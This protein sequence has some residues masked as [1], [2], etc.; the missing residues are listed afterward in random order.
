MFIPKAPLLLVKTQDHVEAV[1][2]E[3]VRF[4][5][6]RGC[7]V[8]C[9]SAFASTE[10]LLDVAKDRDLLIVLGGDGTL[11]SVARKL[12][13][14]ALPFLAFNFG[15]IGFLAEW[16]P[17]TWQETLTSLIAGELVLQSHAGLKWSCQQGGT[18]LQQGFAVNDVVLSRG[19]LARVVPLEIRLND[20]LVA[21]IRSDGL[22]V[23]TP[24]GASGYNLAAGG[25]LVHPAV[26][27][28]CMTAISPIQHGFPS[29]V[30]PPDARV[31][32]TLSESLHHSEMEAFAT[33]DGQEGFAFNE[34]DQLSVELAPNA[35]CFVSASSDTYLAR[36]Q[37]RNFLQ[38]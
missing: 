10:A 7:T 5:A 37:Q 31:N 23:S 29:M 27:A 33:I 22:I 13:V 11:V 9:C 1:A 6:E 32:I 17:D 16:M 18:V 21:S 4:W 24:L 30:L 35:L 34:N 25:A 19:Q 36:L 14:L 26:N 2:Q 20:T 15:R 8:P 12:H 28:L 3:M 38:V